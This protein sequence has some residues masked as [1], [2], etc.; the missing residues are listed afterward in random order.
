MTTW[1]EFL[2]ENAK[3]PFPHPRP[4]LDEDRPDGTTDISPVEVGLLS[5]EWKAQYAVRDEHLLQ[6]L[7]QTLDDILG[8][9]H[10]PGGYNQLLPFFGRRLQFPIMGQQE[11][12]DLDWSENDGKAQVRILGSHPRLSSSR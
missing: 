6:K 9:A 2:V 7:C 3:F 11:V 12:E 1:R 8:D 10:L 4:R 5:P